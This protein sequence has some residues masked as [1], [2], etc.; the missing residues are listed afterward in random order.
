MGHIVLNSFSPM[1]SPPSV[2]L[3]NDL[4]DLTS[5]DMG[6]EFRYGFGKVLGTQN[7]PTLGLASSHCILC[8]NPI[9]C[10]LNIAF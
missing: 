1:E 3:R 4:F 9:K 8:L 2:L 5:R 10:I 6:S 7:H